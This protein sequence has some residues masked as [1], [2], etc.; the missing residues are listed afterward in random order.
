[1][2]PPAV[3]ID[4][5]RRFH[6]GRP[7]LS[8][9]AVAMISFVFGCSGPAKQNNANARV[10]SGAKPVNNNASSQATSGQGDINIREPD[11]Y[12]VAMTISAQETASEAPTPMSTLQFSFSRF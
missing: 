6:A 3:G 2:R 5:Q 9:L 7:M 12:S 4:G 11:R 8:V 1:M 10:T